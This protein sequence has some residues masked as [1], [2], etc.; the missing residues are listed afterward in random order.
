MTDRLGVRG[1]RNCPPPPDNA[2]MAFSVPLLPA[3]FWAQSTKSGQRAQPGQRKQMGLIIVSSQD[4]GGRRVAHL[5]GHLLRCR[6]HPV[7]MAVP[8]VSAAQ[9]GDM[10]FYVRLCGCPSPKQK[11]RQLRGLLCGPHSYSSVE[12]AQPRPPGGQAVRL[13]PAATCSWS[14]QL[15]AE[16]K[17]GDDRPRPWCSL[18]VVCE[19]LAHFPGPWRFCF[20]W[21]LIRSVYPMPHIGGLRDPARREGRPLG[22]P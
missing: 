15:T 21:T 19:A 4:L 18:C 14:S 2:E 7:P 16:W 1:G 9:E 10:L 5:R 22:H 13:K 12:P 20:L 6:A 8:A 17:R 3:Y 11:L